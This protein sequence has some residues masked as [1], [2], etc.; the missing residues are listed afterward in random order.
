MEIRAPVAGVV[1]E[2]QVWTSGGVVPPQETLLTVIPVSEGMEFQ[3]EVSPDAIDTV[4]LGQV[5]RVRFPAFD[6]RSTPELN[7]TV[8]GISPDSV[9]DPATNRSFYRV[10]VALPQDELARLGGAELIP[11]MP[12]EAF[13]QTGNR[14][15]LNI[16]VKPLTDQLIYAFREG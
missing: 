13:L 7:G 12:V 11:G 15:I 4:H 1:H 8:A 14:S 10:D 3:V 9:T 6:Q 16:L 2:L 5:A